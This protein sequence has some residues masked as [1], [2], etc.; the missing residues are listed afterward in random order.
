MRNPAVSGSEI[1][2]FRSL[3]GHS[4]LAKSG[5][6]TLA[7]VYREIE[8]P[9]LKNLQRTRLI[10]IIYSLVFTS[11]VSFLGVM[12]IPDAQRA[13]YLDN[14]IGGLS[15]F[16]AGAIAI[17]LAFHAF[18]VLVGTL[19][20]AG[21][22]NTAIIGSNGVLNRTAE[23]D[24][25]PGW[26][27]QPHPKYDTTSRIINLIAILQIATILLSGGNVIML[28]EA[29]AFGVIWRFAMKGLG[30]LILRFKRPGTQQWKV[31]L[32]FHLGQTEIPLGLGLITLTLFS[33]AI[34][35]A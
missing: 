12:L 23:D 25:L 10:V 28:G 34:I 24:V 27:R 8:A 1:P 4:L 9:K 35:N 19:I 7:Q 33:L 29:Y 3:L 17:R 11:S 14:L 6:E 30:V 13:K 26:F 16:L 15:M 22:V 18:V 31:P 21:A 5:F 20:L 2:F 32:N